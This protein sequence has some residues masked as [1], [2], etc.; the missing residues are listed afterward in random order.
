MYKRK[1]TPPPS[2]APLTVTVP[3]A[4]NLLGVGKSS[5]YRLVRAHKLELIKLNKRALIRYADLERL[6]AG[7]AKSPQPEA[8]A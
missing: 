5:I 3:D 4:A 2:L 8:T 1:R 7:S 6:V